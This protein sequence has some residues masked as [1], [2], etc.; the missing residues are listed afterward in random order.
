MILSHRDLGAVLSKVFSNFIES[1]DGNTSHS[2]SVAANKN[3]KIL[4]TLTMAE[5]PIGLC[6][7]LICGRFFPSNPTLLLALRKAYVFLCFA[8][9]DTCT[10]GY[11]YVGLTAEV[12]KSTAVTCGTLFNISGPSC[13]S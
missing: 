2:W 1:K 8:Y 11:A 12:C 13:M 5:I 6:S 4:A 9:G 3:R 7:N 10:K